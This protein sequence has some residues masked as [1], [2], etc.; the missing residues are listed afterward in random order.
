M[1]KAEARARF[2][3]RAALLLRGGV[4]GRARLV[5]VVRPCGNLHATACACG[6]PW[7]MPAQFG[8][9]LQDVTPLPFVELVGH[10]GFFDAEGW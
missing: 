8:F 10:L 4:I 3:A 1:T 7:H 2:Y 5:D 9:I 6:R